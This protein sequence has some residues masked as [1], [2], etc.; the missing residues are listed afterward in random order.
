MA[1]GK[2][3]G[4]GLGRVAC[5]DPKAVGEALAVPAGARTIGQDIDHVAAFRP[6]PMVEEA[7]P[8]KRSAPAEVLFE[9]RCPKWAE[10]APTA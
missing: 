9:N 4:I 7:G 6:D 10:P 8:G 3:G 5:F 2:I 1:G